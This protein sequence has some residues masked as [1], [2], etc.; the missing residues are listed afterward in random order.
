MLNGCL[1]LLEGLKRDWSLGSLFLL[2]VSL[3]TLFSNAVILLPLNNFCGL[4]CNSLLL[5]LLF[6][7]TSNPF[8]GLISILLLFIL[9]FNFMWKNNFS[10]C[11]S[12]KKIKDCWCCNFMWSNFCSCCN[13]YHSWILLERMIYVYI[14]VCT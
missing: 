2:H 6:V 3:Y 5:L 7:T 12:Y 9:G 10:C 13:S 14:M 8:L 1:I 4:W 11:K